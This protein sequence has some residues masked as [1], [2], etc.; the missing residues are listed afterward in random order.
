MQVADGPKEVCL[1]CNE[2]FDLVTLP[3]HLSS[4]QRSVSD[5]GASSKVNFPGNDF[6]DDLDEFEPIRV[7]R[8]IS[9][10]PGGPSASHTVGHV[11]SIHQ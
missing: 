10:S 1:N 11:V 7:R 4:C 5:Q 2:K 3:V 8:R 6:D 9:Q